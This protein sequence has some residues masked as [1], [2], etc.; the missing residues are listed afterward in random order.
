MYDRHRPRLDGLE[1]LAPSPL[2]TCTLGSAHAS[3]DRSTSVG[4]RSVEGKVEPI[5]ESIAPEVMEPK[6]VRCAKGV[7]SGTGLQIIRAHR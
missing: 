6:R 2:T 4:C 7:L 3:C 1:V 5:L